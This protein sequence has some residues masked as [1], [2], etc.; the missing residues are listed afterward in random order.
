MDSGIRISPNF[1]HGVYRKSG[2]YYTS[3]AV[4][5]T[6][7]NYTLLVDSLYAVPFIVPCSQ[8]FDRIGIGIVTAGAA[9]TEARLGVYYDSG[10]V[11]P[12]NLMLDAGVVAVDS[13]GVQEIAISINLSYALIWLSIISSGTP[14]VRGVN[15]ANVFNFLGRDTV[16]TQ[17]PW[18]FM[19]RA[20]AYGSLPDPFG[21]VSM[22]T[23]NMPAVSLRK[24]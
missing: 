5:A 6:L 4:C 7:A 13:T 24:A 14:I 18:S 2:I 11:S 15:P 16:D 1:H 10:S 21:A 17:L 19:R 20:L 22:T 3:D 8:S 12:G 9:G 23:G